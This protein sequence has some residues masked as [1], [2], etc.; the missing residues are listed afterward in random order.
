[1]TI[2]GYKLAFE[3]KGGGTVSQKFPRI[4]QTDFK[5]LLLQ[6]KE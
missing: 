5:F 3:E 4:L 6:K 1:V 2:L